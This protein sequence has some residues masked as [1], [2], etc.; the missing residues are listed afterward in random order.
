MIWR[1]EF[2]CLKIIPGENKKVYR[3]RLL[4]VILID[5]FP[6]KKVPIGLILTRSYKIVLGMLRTSIASIYLGIFDFSLPLLKQYL[7]F[8]AMLNYF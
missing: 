1:A 7:K 8:L 3:F 6:T 4:I 2:F 5:I